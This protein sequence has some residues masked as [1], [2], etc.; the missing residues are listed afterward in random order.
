MCVVAQHTQQADA[1]LAGRQAA[2]SARES[3]RACGRERNASRDMNTRRTRGQ[4][5]KRGV[6]EN[7]QTA[8]CQEATVAQ[9]YS[10][11]HH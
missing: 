2:A 8:T 1:R 11:G 10:C 3:A 6:V 9:I 7:C 4:R 5:E